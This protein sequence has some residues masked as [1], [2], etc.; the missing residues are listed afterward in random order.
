MFVGM[1]ASKSCDFFHF[2]VEQVKYRS[3]LFFVPHH[4]WQVLRVASPE[5]GESP[6]HL[7]ER[8]RK[9][10]LPEGRLPGHHGQTSKESDATAL[11][12]AIGPQSGCDTTPAP[13]ATLF[14]NPLLNPVTIFRLLLLRDSRLL[15]SCR[16]TVVYRSVTMSDRRK[17]RRRNV[18]QHQSASATSVAFIIQKQNNR[19]M[20]YE[21]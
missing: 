20:Q 3:S 15:L 17:K 7:V 19:A 5:I 1:S 2:L 13:L 9:Y 8:Q 18:R 10:Q 14:F 16:F 12:I 6:T 4:T 21:T 11:E